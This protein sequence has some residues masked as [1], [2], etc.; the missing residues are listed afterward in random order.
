MD[1]QLVAEGF[2][3]PEGPI[4]MNDGSVILTEIKAQRLTRL[5]AAPAFWIAAQTRG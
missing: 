4:A 5:D 1:M 3:F 2:Q